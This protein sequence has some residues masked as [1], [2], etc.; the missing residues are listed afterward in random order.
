M[1]IYRLENKNTFNAFLDASTEDT[2]NRRRILNSLPIHT[3][4]T[5]LL[6]K[7]LK[8]NNV[9]DN[10]INNVLS[11]LKFQKQIIEKVIKNNVFVDEIQEITKDNFE[12]ISPSV[13]LSDYFYEGKIHYTYEEYMEHLALTRKYA[14]KH[15][16]YKLTDNSSR[17]F[18]NIQVLI[19]ENNWIMISKDNSPSIHFVIR[20]PKL[21]SAIE[22]F[23]PPIVE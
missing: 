2:G 7:I 6:T 13:S 22:N 5:E 1:D 8:R 4:S 3:I 17:T 20:H 12:V 14:E 23:I 19:C 18:K 10:D 11:S 16:N 15:S 9:S 21:R